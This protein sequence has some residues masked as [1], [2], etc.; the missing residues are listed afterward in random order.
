MPTNKDTILSI[1]VNFKHYG[2]S[3]LN[4]LNEKQLSEIIQFANDNYHNN[5]H[6]N[7][8]MENH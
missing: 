5:I 1:I 3:V 7:Y 2:I 8:I 6:G 4:V